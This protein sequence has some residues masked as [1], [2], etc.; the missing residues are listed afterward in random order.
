MLINLQ[1]QTMIL[2]FVQKKKTMILKQKM[3]RKQKMIHLLGLIRTRLS[4]SLLSP[5]PNQKH[6]KKKDESHLPKENIH[7]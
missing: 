5:I 7:V 1:I 3:K 4:F 2:K 6:H